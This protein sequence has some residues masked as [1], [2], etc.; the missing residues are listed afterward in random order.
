MVDFK[1]NI[2][3]WTGG[4]VMVDSKFNIRE[5]TGGSNGRTQHHGVDR[6]GVMVD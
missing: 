3:E 2:M 1:L 6:G 5:W 4:G